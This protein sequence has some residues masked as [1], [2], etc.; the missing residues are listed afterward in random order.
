M[1]NN[2]LNSI[3]FTGIISLVAMPSCKKKIDDAYLNPNAAVVQ[4]IE[5]ILPG[6]IGGFTWFSST[7]G[8]T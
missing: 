2:F 4:P 8:T 5:S 1:K 6:V 7:Q 3:I